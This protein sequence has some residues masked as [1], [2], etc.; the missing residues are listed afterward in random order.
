MRIFSVIFITFIL[1][2]SLTAT[3]FA[4]PI[5]QQNQT[6]QTTTSVVNNSSSHSVPVANVT[7]T[8]APVAVNTSS[9]NQT[10]QKN[11]SQVQV[12]SGDQQFLF[13]MNQ[14]WIPDFFDIKG[15]MDGSTTFGSDLP[16]MMNLTADYARIRLNKNINETNGYSL[17]PSVSS[18]RT[19][20]Q[21]GA[22]RCIKVIDSVMALNRSV[23]SFGQDVPTR[24]AALSLYGTWLEYRTMKAYNLQNIS[25]PDIAEVP[26]DQFM[27]VMGAITK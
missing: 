2:I 7:V 17:S 11:S 24:T 1:F 15:R 14:Y 26:P 9:K 23:G 27:Q 13:L 21:T 22:T 10:V 5:P 19:E 3:G 16:Q 12:S 8:P 6:V 20:Y 18:L 4:A 25:Y